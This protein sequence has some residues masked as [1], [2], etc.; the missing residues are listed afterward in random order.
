ML[1]S[2]LD[3]I[4]QKPDLRRASWRSRMFHACTK[5]LYYL[6]TCYIVLRFDDLRIKITIN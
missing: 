4:Y 2:K 1:F 5:G 3:L 6:I